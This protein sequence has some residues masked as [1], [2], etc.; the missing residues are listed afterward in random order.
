MIQDR[1][2][3]SLIDVLHGLQVDLSML[4]EHAA[5]IPPDVQSLLIP[6]VESLLWLRQALAEQ[7]PSLRRH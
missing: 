7:T 5:R 1:P 4:V 3:P 6:S 2:D